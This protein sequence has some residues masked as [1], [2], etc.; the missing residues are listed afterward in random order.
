MSNPYLDET[1]YPSM[2]GD[3]VPPS[4]DPVKQFVAKG[5]KIQRVK[6]NK[7]KT[8]WIATSPFRGGKMASGPSRKIG[9]DVE[10]V[11]EL[12]KGRTQKYLDRAMGDFTHQDMGSRNAY[13]EQRPEYTRKKSLRQKGISRAIDRLTKE[14]VE[15]VDELS[16]ATLKSYIKGRGETVHFDKKDSKSARDTAIEKETQGKAKE[17]EGWHDESDWLDN[18]ARKGAKNVAKAVIKVAKKT[19]ENIEQV[20]ELNIKTVKSYH[21]KSSDQAHASL[22]GN[23]AIHHLLKA[24]DDTTG[25]YKGSEKYWQKKVDKREAG[26]KRSG[27]RIDKHNKENPP[28]KATPKPPERQRDQYGYG[29][30][31]GRH[32]TGDSL[33]L[34][35]PMIAELSSNLLGRYKSKA[36]AQASTMDKEA[37]ATKDQGK[38][39]SLLDKAHKRYKGIIKATGKQFDNDM[40]EGAKSLSNILEANGKVHANALH[41]S[42]PH[43]VNGETKYKV[44]T[45]GKNFNDGI[46]A[47][48]HLSDA[49]LDDAAEMGAKVKHIK[50]VSE[51]TWFGNTNKNDSKPIT[52]KTS[53][54]HVGLKAREERTK[55]EGTDESI[56][57][58]ESPLVEDAQQ[59]AISNIKTNVQ[60]KFTSP[61]KDTDV[62]RD[63]DVDD[64][65]LKQKKKHHKKLKTFRTYFESVDEA[66]SAREAL[67]KAADFEYKAA[68][69]DDEAL[70]RKLKGKAKALRR[71]A[72][73]AQKLATTV[74]LNI[75]KQ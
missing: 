40:K 45:V 51:A 65:E 46:K 16:K 32:Y 75:S 20:D 69:T 41:V 26:L 9:E 10:Q 31:P 49:E 6:P 34:N 57:S 70:E 38:A 11:D 3:A 30:E 37:F 22:S 56:T 13:P 8:N 21:T 7:G 12:S 14:D 4:K 48:E 55:G 15:Q 43:K 50:S 59:K 61:D 64:P 71:A 23:T 58:S 24:K 44:H 33:E 68:N 2:D 36:S 67:S 63:Y 25:I 62:I 28:P 66:I 72:K 17:A 73:L 60:S 27:A 1:W 52:T 29:G 19:N 39:R 35:G 42:G 47:G 53:K 18:R 74:D 5:G 54:Q